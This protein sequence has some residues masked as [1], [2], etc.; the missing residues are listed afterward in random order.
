MP[1]VGLGT[2][3]AAP[4]EAGYRHIDCASVYD[5]EGEIGQALAE[6]FAKGVIKRSDVFITSKLWNTAH[7]KSQ[8]RPALEKTLKDLQLTYLDLYLVH[9][10]VSFVH[11]SEEEDDGTITFDKVPLEETWHAMEDL[12]Q[13]GGLVKAIGVSNYTLLTLLDLLSYAK[14]VPAVN[15]VEVSPFFIRDNL[16][17]KC[18]ENGIHVVGYSPFG[19]DLVMRPKTGPLHS[20][21]IAEIAKAHGKTPAQVILRWTLQRGI[22]VIPKTV[23]KERLVENLQ[24]ADFT[25]T[26]K[27]IQAIDDLNTGKTVVNILQYWGIDIWQ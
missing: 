21:V 14:V 22:S 24:S 23:G 2:W 8:V 20:V 15:Q 26:S 18:A 6:V 19:G 17:S 7:K 12:L 11:K 1:M 13:T 10:P 3:K 27:Q 4:K 25:L 9:W 16:Y 5:N